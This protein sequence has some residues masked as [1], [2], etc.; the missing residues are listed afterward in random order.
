MNIIIL[1]KLL[2]ILFQ[3]NMSSLTVYQ[4]YPSLVDKMMR[5]CDL[6]FSPNSGYLAAATSKGIVNMYRWVMSLAVFI[7]GELDISC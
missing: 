1:L 7:F 4:N 5:P 2:T 3:V 6:D